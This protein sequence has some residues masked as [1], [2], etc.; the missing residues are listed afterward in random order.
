MC[1]NAK[2]IIEKLDRPDVA[3]QQA[4]LKEKEEET[5]KEEIK[6]PHAPEQP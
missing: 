4:I 2:K 3:K 5:K 6:A 1:D